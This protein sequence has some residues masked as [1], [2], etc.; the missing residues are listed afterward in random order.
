MSITEAQGLYRTVVFEKQKTSALDA[1]GTPRS[2]TTKLLFHLRYRT[3]LF[4]ALANTG[5]N[6]STILVH[7]FLSFS[8]VS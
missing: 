1:E 7:V 4:I 2:E 8:Q 6:T 3:A 5:L